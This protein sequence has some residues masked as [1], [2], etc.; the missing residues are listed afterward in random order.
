MPIYVGYD[1]ADVYHNKELF[2]LNDSGLMKFKAGCPPCNYQQKGQVWGN[3][4]YDWTNHKQ[5]N[6]NWWRQ[7]FNRLLDMVDII[8][9]DHFIGYQRFYKIPINDATAENGHWDISKGDELFDS[10]TSII[11]CLFGL[12]GLF[13]KNT[14]FYMINMNVLIILGLSSTLHHYFYDN[15]YFWKV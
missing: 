2:Q 10:L 8:R 5:S 11:T 9:L 15:I 3:P 7:R 13:S 4:V 1:S 12:A 6:F 14:Y